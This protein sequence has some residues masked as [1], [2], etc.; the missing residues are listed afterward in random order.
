MFPATIAALLSHSND[1]CFVLPKPNDYFPHQLR[2]A[3]RL[4]CK[5]IGGILLLVDNHKWLELYYHGDRKNC[6]VIRAVAM[7]AAATAQSNLKYDTERV[8]VVYGFLCSSCQSNRFKRDHPSKASQTPHT[9]FV[10]CCNKHDSH[11]PLDSEICWL[12]DV[13]KPTGESL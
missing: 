13:M 2:N 10:I 9:L 8:S 7:D 4:T 3:V 12:S 11:K 5:S 6:P 1:H